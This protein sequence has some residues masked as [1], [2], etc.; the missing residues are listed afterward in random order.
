ME[1]KSLIQV[2]IA[3]DILVTV[4]HLA[5]D[6]RVTKGEAIERVLQ[7]GLDQINALPFSSPS[8]TEQHS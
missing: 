8:Q 6:W 3:T 1:D 2:R 7:I 5:V 4:E